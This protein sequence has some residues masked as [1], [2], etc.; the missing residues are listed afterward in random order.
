MKTLE[1]LKLVSIIFVDSASTSPFP[2]WVG[3]SLFTSLILAGF[4]SRCPLKLASH[5][6]ERICGIGCKLQVL[7][8]EVVMIV[9]GKSSS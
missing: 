9:P 7:H 3:S 2:A 5:K 4:K 6:S 8:Q 1:C